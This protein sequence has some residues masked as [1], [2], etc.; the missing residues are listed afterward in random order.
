MIKH[1]VSS[2]A[3]T[4]NNYTIKHSFDVTSFTSC[5]YPFTF[6]LLPRFIPFTISFADVVYKKIM[7]VGGESK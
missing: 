7:C 6:R 1:T 5:K 3:R 2:G 4:F